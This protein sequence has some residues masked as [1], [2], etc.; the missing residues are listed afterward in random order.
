LYRYNNNII[1]I[2]SVNSP[3]LFQARI[4]EG[5]IYLFLQPHFS[6]SH[7]TYETAAHVNV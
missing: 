3:E 4:P 6:L 1:L 7:S 5:A 2:I